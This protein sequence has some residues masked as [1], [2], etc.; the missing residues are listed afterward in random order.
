MSLFIPRF[1]A[2][3]G[4]GGILFEI[5][6]AEMKDSAREKRLIHEKRARMGMGEED[7]GC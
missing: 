4:Q 5:S 6:M 3:N 2:R 1:A 7:K